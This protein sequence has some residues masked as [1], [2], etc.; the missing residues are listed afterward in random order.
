MMRCDMRIS[1]WDRRRLHLVAA[2]TFTYLATLPFFGA[3]CFGAGCFGGLKFGKKG[4]HERKQ[5]VDKT[6]GSII[7]FRF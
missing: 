2:G 6:R 5:V 7:M 1:W 4:K 3:G